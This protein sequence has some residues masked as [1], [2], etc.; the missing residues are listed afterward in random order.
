MNIKASTLALLEID[1]ELQLVLTKHNIWEEG[2]LS[3]YSV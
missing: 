1:C 3:L 2:C